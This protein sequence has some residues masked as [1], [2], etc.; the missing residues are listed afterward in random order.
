VHSTL[1]PHPPLFI[2]PQAWPK[3]KKERKGGPL[4]CLLPCLIAYYD[5]FL[6]IIFGANGL[7][8]MI[9]FS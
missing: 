3:G 4:L 9:S 2:I 8:I 6:K 7:C 1:Q 5:F